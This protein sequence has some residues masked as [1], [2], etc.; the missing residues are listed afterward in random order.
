M[1]I[2]PG[3]F[4]KLLR[5]L[6][7]L[8]QAP[9]NWNALASRDLLSTSVCI[10]RSVKD[11]LCCAENKSGE[12]LDL[13]CLILDLLLKSFSVFESS[14]ISLII[15]QIF[16]N[17]LLPCRNCY[18]DLPIKRRHIHREV[19]VYC[20]NNILNWSEYVSAYILVLFKRSP[21]F[22][23]LFFI[24]SGAHSWQAYHTSNRRQECHW[25][26]PQLCSPSTFKAYWHHIP[27]ATRHDCRWTIASYG[28]CFD[29]WSTCWY[30]N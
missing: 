12:T 11:T 16:F 30:S 25:S 8:K 23:W 28:T 10:I 26:R 14:R 7:G 15:W 27:L 24:I 22:V 2:A 29:Y 5:S 18:S 6:Y 4:L 9:R 13:N 19:A 3:R 17:S 21:G 1:T 20:C